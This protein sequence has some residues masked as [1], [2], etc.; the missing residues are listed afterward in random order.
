MTRHKNEQNS[1]IKDAA[2]EREAEMQPTPEV[3]EAFDA[4]QDRTDNPVARDGTTEATPV[5]NDPI[6]QRY[7]A[8]EAQKEKDLKEY[9]KQSDGEPKV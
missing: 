2:K 7:E 1:A 5:V 3:H 9:V 4:M 6:R 8:A